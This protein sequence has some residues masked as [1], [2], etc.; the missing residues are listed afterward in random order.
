M[1]LINSLFGSAGGQYSKNKKYLSSDV[2]HRII[3]ST[4]INSLTRAE[5]EV[6]RNAIIGAKTG[7]N[8]S[9]YKVYN[10][11][12]ELKKQKVLSSDIDRNNI[13][14]AIKKYFEEQ[15]K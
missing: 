14:Q 4:R 5:A 1:G 11:L 13:L 8:I 6:V 12:R 9:L 10:V 3:S 15:E 2:I 7:N